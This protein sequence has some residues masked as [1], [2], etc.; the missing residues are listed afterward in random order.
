MNSRIN[1]TLVVIMLSDE[2]APSL[3]G[4]AAEHQT[5]ALRTIET[6]RVAQ[7]FWKEH[8]PLDAEACAGGLT[9][10]TGEGNAERDL[11]SILDDVELH[12]GLAASGRPATAL[13]VLGIEANEVVRDALGALGFT[14]I[15]SIPDGGFLARWN[16]V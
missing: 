12:H 10:F 4:L 11:L 8:P 1:D 7:E 15:E 3:P 16:R 13:R 14:R 2:F 9:L 5:W 6:E